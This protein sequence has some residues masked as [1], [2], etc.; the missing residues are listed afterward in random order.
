MPN[1]I[2]HEGYQSLSSA[3]MSS[4]HGLYGSSYNLHDVISRYS[5]NL[6]KL[7]GQDSEY[8]KHFEISLLNIVVIANKAL[9]EEG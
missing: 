2:L 5:L 1:A 7:P 3:L 4:I 8:L 6:G 9:K